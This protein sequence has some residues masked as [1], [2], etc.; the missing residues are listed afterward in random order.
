MSEDKITLLLYQPKMVA[1]KV[2]VSRKSPVNIF[3]Q[4]FPEGRNVYLYNGFFLSGTMLIGSY[5]M[6][7][8]DKV[9]VFPVVERSKKLNLR[10]SVI[11]EPQSIT[12][13]SSRRESYK[14]DVMKEVARIKDLK[15][16]KLE[17]KR[18]CYSKLAL[19]TTQKKSAYLENGRSETKL[20]EERVCTGPSCEPLPIFWATTNEKSYKYIE[21]PPDP[22]LEPKTLI[23]V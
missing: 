8:M 13:R 17:L 22:F 20:A 19:K 1:K 7:N 18:K 23:N 6:N 15:L 14:S 9:F 12:N 16:S 3:N 10:E 11:Q 5:M 21:S 4:L 2:I